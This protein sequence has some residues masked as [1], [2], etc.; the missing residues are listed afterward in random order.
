MFYILLNDAASRTRVLQALNAGDINAVF[1]Y[2]PLHT[3]RAGRRFARTVGELPQTES[4]AE[5]LIRLP[6][7]IGM[8]QSDVEHAATI[9]GRTIG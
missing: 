2:V 9:V 1:H 7:W 5:R 8:T 3:S 6:M 4:I